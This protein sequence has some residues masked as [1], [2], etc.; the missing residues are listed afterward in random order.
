MDISRR[1]L[2]G[3]LGSLA[4]TGS[5][6]RD[7][8]ALAVS[9]WESPEPI[10]IGSQKQLFVDDVIIER[11]DNLKR[12]LNQP[13]KY[14]G[15]P[16]LRPKKPWEGRELWL[17]GSVI[18]DPAEKQF[19]AWYITRAHHQGTSYGCYA[20]SKDGIHW[21]KPSLGLRE[22]EGSKENNIT[23]WYG[24]GVIHSP[25]DPDPSRRYKALN[26]RRAAFS[27]DGLH[28]TTPEGSKDI[29][30]DLAGDNVIPFCYDETTRRYLAFGKVLRTFGGH[31][32]RSVSVS[33]SDDFLKWTPAET[34]LVPDSHDDELAH[35]RVMKLR[36]RYHFVDGPEWHLAQFYMM[37]GFPYEGI[38]LGLLSVLDISGFP[39]GEKR[40]VGGGGEHGP[41]L[42][43]L[44]SSRDLHHWRRVCERQL[45]LSV[46]EPSTWE[47]RRI[48]TTVNRPIIVGDEIWIY[49][50]GW[51][52]SKSHPYTLLT[53][54]EDKAHS[55]DALQRRF[56]DLDFSLPLGS[57]GLA[58][59]RL[60]GWVS[61]NAGREE[62]TVLTKPL[63]FKGS[64]LV[65]N[66]RSEGGI[67]V[68]VVSS[69]RKAFRLFGRPSD[70]VRGDSL[71]HT[72][73]WKGKPDLSSL[74][75]S[76][77]Q[78]RIRARNAQLYSFRFAS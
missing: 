57:V 77:I 60:D 58:K 32:R 44:T 41:E 21:E 13:Q 38:Y 4:V 8:K 2:V 48:Y 51:Q 56:P 40:I 70:T 52:I 26:K 20:V 6:Y 15:N 39:P 24:M 71:A 47:G 50:G 30:G 59:L 68:E 61:L 25:E 64:Q 1:R 45:F 78:L 76:T 16:V 7:S 43:E 36:E 54:S 29:P 67:T 9:A 11:M 55:V 62:G 31:R 49:Y 19:E 66:A 35:E 42:V 27:P 69:D 63:V 65:L 10:A 53:P 17:S 34:I 33:F 5:A 73:M 22:Y 23:D 75:G 37:A 28:W 18:F 46:G 12:V 14:S 3:L 74:L 72:V